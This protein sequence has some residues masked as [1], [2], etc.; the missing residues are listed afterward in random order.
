MDF[1]KDHGCNSVDDLLVK[2][3]Y[4]AITPTDILNFLKVDLKTEE[5]QEEEPAN[6]LAKAFKSAV[7]RTKRSGSLIRVDG[8]DDVLVRFGKCCNPIPGDPILGYITR[9]RGLVIHRADCAKAFEL[10]QDRRIDVE[11]NQ[12]KDQDTSRTVRLRVLSKDVPGLLK[13]MSEVFSS[14][15]VNILNAQARTT[16]DLK[17]VCLFDVTIKDTKHLSEVIAALS[18]LKGILGVTRITRT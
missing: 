7:S 16:K 18:K 6:F 8:L 17:A 13:D 15:G 3:G 11:W 5:N 9:G 10:D 1:S 2:V 12:K 4:G 14:Q